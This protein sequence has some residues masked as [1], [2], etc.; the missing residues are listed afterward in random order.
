VQETLA[1]GP[2]AL[3]E[4]LKLPKRAEERGTIRSA[5]FRGRYLVRRYCSE[6]TRARQLPEEKRIGLPSIDESVTHRKCCRRELTS[7]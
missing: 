1:L 6:A 4:G 2:P 3:V 5:S 7:L